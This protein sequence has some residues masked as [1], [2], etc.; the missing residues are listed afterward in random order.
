LFGCVYN[1]EL[2][3]NGIF[4]VVGFSM[5]L[6]MRNIMVISKL[7]D[8]EVIENTRDLALWLIKNGQLNV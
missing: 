5:K 1:W 4:W 6:R 7:V 3:G 2:T 8:P